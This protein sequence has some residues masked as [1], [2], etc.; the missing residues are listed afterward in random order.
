MSTTETATKISEEAVAPV[1]AAAE[2]AETAEKKPMTAKERK[3][4]EQKRREEARAAR[5]ER[6]QAEKDNGTGPWR[7]EMPRTNAMLE[8]YYAENGVMDKEEFAKYLESMRTPLPTTF[9]VTRGTYMAELVLAKLRALQGAADVEAS[10]RPQPLPWYPH[11]SAWYLAP[12]RSEL[13]KSAALA[14]LKQFLVA[15]N[16][17]GN[18]TRQEAVS[19]IPPLML[20]VHSEHR[21]LDMCAA[22][23]SKTTELIELLHED[24]APGVLPT[25]FV[26]ANDV[27]IDRCF[28]LVHQTKRM[29]SPCFVVTCHEAEKYPRRAPN[30][31]DFGFDRVLCD[32][33]CSGD[34]TLRK[35]LDVWKKWNPRMAH[36]QHRVQVAIA[37]RGVFLLRPGGRLVYSTCSLNPIEDEAVV[38]ELLRTYKGQLKLVDASKELP[39]LK[40]A[41]G[42][43]SW[44]VYYDKGKWASSRDELDMP[45]KFKKAV[46]DS[47]FAPTPEEAAEMHLERCMRILP[48]LQDT[49]G[50]FV[51]VL[52][53]SADA[54]EHPEDPLEKPKIVSVAPT[55]PEADDGDDGEDG[56][57]KKK[58]KPPAKPGQWPLKSKRGQRA[59]DCDEPLRVCAHMAGA[60]EAF[61]SMRKFYAIDETKFAFDQLITRNKDLSKL[62]FVSRGIF[63]LIAEQEQEQQKMEKEAEAAAA[64][65][66]VAIPHHK[67]MTI[68]HAG[69]KLFQVQHIRQTVDC[70]FRLS[71][72]SLRWIIPALGPQRIV[73]VP[74]ASLLVLLTTQDPK[75]EAFEDKDFAARLEALTPGCYVLR[76]KEY[77][78][79]YFCAW[80][81]VV[82]THLLV[83][84]KEIL[85]LCNILAPEHQVPIKQDQRNNKQLAKKRAREEE[86]KAAAAA[87]AASETAPAKEE[88][89]TPSSPKH[90]SASVTP[91]QD[92]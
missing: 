15:Q 6:F 77:E 92:A 55:E 33:P 8:E 10:A 16:E 76:V 88:E 75:L 3:A 86:Q 48:H 17:Q 9:R 72:E 85:S 40:R 74:L 45:A 90:K 70:N 25:G 2:T 28:M 41:P 68:V 79:M 73:E 24:C 21:V 19:M 82:S 12:G 5:R 46:L 14:E 42:I 26:V 32:V 89:D 61:A 11:E 60:A 51:A 67:C 7:R 39:E 13:R 31:S 4:A 65:G 54:P 52:E 30:G 44:K 36:R 87:A 1:A 83:S 27:D 64:S 50:F 66:T 57:K 59:K 49:G 84:K 35:N 81:G 29:S 37:K 62:L 69:L 91:S 22:P 38:A 58:V 80:R 20:D 78:H 47:C 56:D 18:I 63:D 43:S 23:G 53:K 71:M 34:G